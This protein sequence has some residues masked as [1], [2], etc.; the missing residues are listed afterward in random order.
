V[1]VTAK[2]FLAGCAAALGLALLWGCGPAAVRDPGK[3]AAHTQ[4]AAHTVTIGATAYQP[5]TLTVAVGDSITWVNQ[6]PFAHTVTAEEGDFDSGDIPAGRSWTYTATA[7]GEFD[8]ECTYHR[9][10]KGTLRVK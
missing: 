6:D 5:A 2:P 9:T 8:Y 7:Q 4:P 3:P 1:S 10:M